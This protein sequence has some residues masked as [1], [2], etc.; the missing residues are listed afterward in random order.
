MKRVLL[1]AL[2]V[3][4]AASAPACADR[5]TAGGPAEG[6]QVVVRLTAGD[7]EAVAQLTFGDAR[8]TPNVGSYCWTFGQGSSAGELCGDTAP[9]IVVPK[10]HLVV[11]RGVTLRVEGD[12]TKV[13]AKVATVSQDGNGP[14]LHV[15]QELTFAA[16]AATIDVPPGDYTLEVDGTWPQG[17]VPF[18]FGIRVS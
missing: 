15:V 5:V 14:T 12:A 13:S 3:A 1:L 17:Q 8:Q 11:P 4:V 18:F 7:Q 6:P 2:V 10:D 9:D 16:G